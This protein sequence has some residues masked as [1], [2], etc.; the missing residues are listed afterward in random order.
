MYANDKFLKTYRPPKQEVR[1]SVG[2]SYLHDKGGH[3][4]TLRLSMGIS[5][6]QM[7]IAMTAEEADSLSV[8]LAYYAKTVRLQ[9]AKKDLP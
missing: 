4:V 8:D 2:M 5:E 1:S 9:R 3:Y 7:T 6:P